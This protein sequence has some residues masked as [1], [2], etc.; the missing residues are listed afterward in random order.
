MNHCHFGYITK[1]DKE[2]P[3]CR[4]D[5]PCYWLW[6]HSLLCF[7][8]ALLRK[9]AHGLELYLL[10]L[11]S[12]K[13]HGLEFYLPLFLSRDTWTY[14]CWAQILFYFI[15]YYFIYLFICC[16]DYNSVNS[17][18]PNTSRTVLNMQLVA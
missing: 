18:N 2:T 7:T 8:W 9:K 17:L 16:F 15:I 13:P 12:V 3:T 5:G 6:I 1:N 10:P 11:F 14:Y 4:Q